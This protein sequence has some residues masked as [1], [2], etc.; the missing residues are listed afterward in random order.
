MDKPA[1]ITSHDVVD[2]VR[3][4]FQTKRVGHTGTLD[5]QATGLLILLIGEATK[6][7]EYLIG[8]D[9][10]YEGKMRLGVQS[11][12][13]DAAGKITEG[14]GKEIPADIAEIREAAA[15]LTGK[16][17][18]V[19]PPYSAKKHAGK[20]LYEYARAGNSPEI[21][22]REV[23]VMEFEI[24]DREEGEAPDEV[25]FGIDCSSGTYVRSLVHDLGQMLG[26]GAILTELHRTDVGPFEI[27]QAHQLEDLRNMKPHEL[28]DC[29]IPIRK[30]LFPMPTIYLSPG[31]ENWLRKGQAVPYNMVETGDDFR[32]KPRSLVVASRLMGEG[33]A[34][35]RV[36]AAPPSPPPKVM[37]NSP[38]PWFHPIKQFDIP[39]REV[40]MD[41]EL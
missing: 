10:S 6:I 24:L 39:P 19:P 13:Y 2:Q 20:K 32:P 12:T 28:R 17:D 8:A 38:S 4:T 40:G 33:V 11:D 14:P 36:E 34:I 37:A 25:A 5:P 31:A 35:C 29:L 21:P 9:K 23:N 7:S 22:A 16:I 15:K 27:E 1:G 18:Q 41:E 30:A 26:C 3:K